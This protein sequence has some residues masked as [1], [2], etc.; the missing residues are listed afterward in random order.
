M[1][2]LT[3][4]R[5][6]V[7]VFTLFVVACGT[8]PAAADGGL[9]QEERY[10]TVE[11]ADLVVRCIRDKGLTISAIETHEM[12]PSDA[13]VRYKWP[14]CHMPIHEIVSRLRP[15]SPAPGAARPFEAGRGDDSDWSL[16]DSLAVP[17]STDGGGDLPG[18]ERRAVGVRWKWHRDAEVL[19]ITTPGTR[20]LHRT[21]PA[22]TYTG[23][24]CSIVKS[25]TEASQDSSG[26]TVI[27]LCRTQWNAGNPVGNSSLSRARTLAITVPTTIEAALVSLILS[28][29]QR[30]VM[31]SSFHSFRDGGAGIDWLVRGGD[32]VP[33][34]AAPVSR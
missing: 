24:F 13:A 11:V 32:P 18:T 33:K 26:Q 28:S 3:P 6:A 19:T 9:D 10:T 15:L 7:R 2:P 1:A 5:N 27:S 29:G 34:P 21:V 8:G 22:A 12:A 20:I 16:S 17:P 14:G 31:A 25:L 4:H 23:T 30:I